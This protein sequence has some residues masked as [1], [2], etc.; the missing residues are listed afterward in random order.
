[1]SP[2]PILKSA[3]G[4]AEIP[5]SDPRLHSRYPIKLDLQYKLLSRGR[6]QHL[7]CGRTLNMSSGGVLFEADD[8]LEITDILPGS[9]T[10]E[11]VLDWPL[12]LGQVCMLKLVVR[13][14]IVRRRPLRVSSS[15]SRSNTA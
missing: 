4:S 5:R 14:R 7:G 2:A 11:L 6:V 9:P 15:G 12:L 13:G 10:V 3:P 1:M 8:I